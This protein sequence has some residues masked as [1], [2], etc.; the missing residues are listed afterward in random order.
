MT[1]MT[2]AEKDAFKRV[3]MMTGLLAVPL[4]YIL[5]NRTSVE[6]CGLYDKF[7]ALYRNQ[8]TRL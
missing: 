1:N 6:I 3:S 8:S 4:N 7:F 5:K 2:Q